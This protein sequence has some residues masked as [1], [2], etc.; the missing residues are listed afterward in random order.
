MAKDLACMI[1]FYLWK[2][3][4]LRG[5]GKLSI[6]SG[7]VEDTRKHEYDS[8]IVLYILFQNTFFFPHDDFSGIIN[9]TQLKS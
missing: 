8:S 2:L 7:E 9:I 4:C 5:T 3:Q 1:L 6:I